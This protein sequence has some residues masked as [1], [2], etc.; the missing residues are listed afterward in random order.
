VVGL[1]E[2]VIDRLYRELINV[3][4]G[5]RRCNR[6]KCRPGPDFCLERNEQF[7]WSFDLL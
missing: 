2:I 1:D 5:N 6:G 7:K 4:L 3:F